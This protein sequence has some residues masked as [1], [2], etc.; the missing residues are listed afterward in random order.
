MVTQTWKSVMEE[1]DNTRQMRK[2]SLG[3][4]IWVVTNWLR[5]SGYPCQ[6]AVLKGRRHSAYIAIILQSKAIA[7]LRHITPLTK[8]ASHPRHWVGKDQKPVFWSHLFFYQRNQTHPPAVEGGSTK[9]APGHRKPAVFHLQQTLL[10]T[11]LSFKFQVL[12]WK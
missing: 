8:K 5:V 3:W 12:T 10:F 4:H 6:N 2:T 11:S 9:W 7:P 1:G